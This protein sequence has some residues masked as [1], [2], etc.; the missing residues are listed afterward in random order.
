MTIALQFCEACGTAQYPSREVCRACL[1]DMLVL[2]DVTV[3]GTVVSEGVIHRSLDEAWLAAGPVRI[4]AV[5][6]TPDLR[7]IAM[8]DP[9]VSVGSSVELRRQP[10]SPGTIFARAAARPGNQT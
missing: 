2:R 10:T 5:A 6:V 9:D 3:R 4:G 7:F 8:L 1:S